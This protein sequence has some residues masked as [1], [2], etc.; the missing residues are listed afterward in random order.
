MSPGHGN[1]PEITTPEAVQESVA[2]KPTDYDQ[3]IAG[4]GR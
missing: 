3:S 2:T 1:G 4:G